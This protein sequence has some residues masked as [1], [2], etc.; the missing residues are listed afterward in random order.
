M[1]FWRG[2]LSILIS[3]LVDKSLVV[4]ETTGRAQGRYR[5]LE[6]I[7]EYALEKLKAAGEISAM[8]DLYLALFVSRTEE[9]APKLTGSYQQLWFNWLETEHDN[10]RAALAWALESAPTGAP[11]DA[12]IEAGLRI[13]N[14]L[15]QFWSVRNYWQEGLAWFERLLAQADDRIPLDVHVYACTYAAFLAEWR[16]NSPAAIKYGRRGVELGEAAGEEG[17]PILAFALGGLGS[18]MRVAGDY[19]A[20]FAIGEQYIELFRKLGDP[21]LYELGMGV[22]VQGSTSMKL[23]KFDSAHALLEE[24]IT[25]AREAGDPFRTAIALNFLG[26]LARIEQQYT[27]AQAFY[28]ESAVMLRDLGDERDLAGTLQN[29]GHNC[30]HLG[31]IERA[32]ALFQ[33]SMAL[34]QAQQN[35]DGIAECLIGF[36]SL[37]VAWHL[38][39]IGARL[40]AAAATAGWER[41]AWEWPATRIE[42]EQTIALVGAQLGG[43]TFEKEQAVGRAL[44]L[45]QAVEFARQL[46]IHVETTPRTRDKLGDLTEREREVVVLIARGKSNREIAEELVLSKRTVE[47]HAANILSKLELTNR[48]QVVRWALEKGLVEASE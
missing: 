48:A 10:I 37:A 26:D 39:D 24:G 45:E 19:Q 4:A 2:I 42:Y 36:A 33:E 6:T 30:L 8:R 14:A 20:L 23:G 15:H 38:P 31:N 28:E 46:Q 47:K 29:L 32:K 11:E 34:Q 3:S 18:A 35:K 27:Q 40:L 1:G 21:Y 44:S 22:L 17:K 9:I 43:E 25:L 13:A 16:G 5:L 12:H 7:R 41:R